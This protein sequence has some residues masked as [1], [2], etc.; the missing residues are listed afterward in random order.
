MQ[1]VLYNGC[2][3]VVVIVKICC[4]NSVHMSIILQDDR[5]KKGKGLLTANFL[6]RLLKE[7]QVFGK[8]NLP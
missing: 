7:D 5:N 2:K 8:K 6:Q 3:T 4:E 1:V